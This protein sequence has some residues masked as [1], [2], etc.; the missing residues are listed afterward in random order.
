M[1]SLKVLSALLS[2]PQRDMLMAL[3]EMAEVVADEDVLPRENKAAVLDLIESL[4]GADLM[5][6]QERY[7][8]LFDRGRALSL[9]IF[10]HV[11]GE[12]RDRGQAMVNLMNL[13]RANGFE[14][15]A[16]ELPDYVPLLLEYLSHRSR[17]QASQ[18]LQDAMPVLSLLGARLAER[19][20]PYHAIFDALAGFAG[21]PE[22]LE[23]IRTQAQ[24]EGP[25]ETVIHM[26]KIWEEEAVIFMPDA[27]ACQSQAPSV[28]P[29]RITPRVRN[30][31]SQANPL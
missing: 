23:T 16:R 1:L 17:E 3:D 24:S 27:G 30:H 14:I 29:V 19:E 4:R 21:E 20:S 8:A 15:A 31:D 10:E 18:L 9:H 28:H 26:D 13:Y 2:Y 6:L 11:H 12:S 7:V 5:D 22:D 25:D